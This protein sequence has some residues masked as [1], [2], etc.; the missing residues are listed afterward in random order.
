MKTFLILF[1]ITLSS[2]IL[3]A[4]Y[5]AFVNTIKLGEYQVPVVMGALSG[6]LAFML[7]GLI[8][9]IIGLIMKGDKSNKKS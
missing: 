7:M 2:V 8:P 4:C 9:L 6:Y 1:G 3:F 5:P